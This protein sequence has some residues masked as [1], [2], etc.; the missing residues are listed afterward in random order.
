MYSDKPYSRQTERANDY[1]SIRCRC[2]F[3][4]MSTMHSAWSE[5]LAVDRYAG[6]KR[7]F[8][9]RGRSGVKDLTVPCSEEDL[10]A[11]NH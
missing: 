1:P 4:Q 5:L 9:E 11:I 2:L 7:G 3:S 10:N 6:A 8:L